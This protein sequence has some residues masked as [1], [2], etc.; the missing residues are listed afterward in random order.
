MVGMAL[1]RLSLSAR[2]P[3]L[4]SRKPLVKIGVTLLDRRRAWLLGDG[5]RID[6]WYAKWLEPQ[7]RLIDFVIHHDHIAGC[8]VVDFVTQDGLWNLSSLELFLLVDIISLIAAQLA[9]LP[10]HG[11]DSRIWLGNKS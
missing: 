9:P 3:T 10:E 6:F 2:M 1:Q 8:K 11:N 7:A 5:Q 4:T